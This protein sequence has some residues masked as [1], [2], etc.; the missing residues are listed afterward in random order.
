MKPLESGQIRVFSTCPPSKDSDNRDYVRRVGDIARWSEGAGCEGILVYTDNSLVDPWLL[1]RL[2]VEHTETL[3]PLVAVQPVYMHPYSVAKMVASFGFLHGRRLWLNI[4]AGGF[5]NDLAAMNDDTPHDDRYQRAVEYALII[6]RLLSGTGPVTLAGKYHSVT[7]LKMTPPLDPELEPG[8]MISGSSE[9]GLQAAREIGAMAVRYPKPPGEEEPLTD[10]S[11][12]FGAR[13]GIIA[14]DD[15][16][17]AWKVALER[18][19]EDRRGQITHKLAMKVS[20]SS[21]HHQLSGAEEGD[22]TEENPYWLG[23]FHNYKTF[24]PY[25]VGTYE[26]VGQE[27]ASYLNLGF[28]SFILDVPHRRKSCTTPASPFR[29]RLPASTLD[30]AASG[31]S[32]PAGGA[33]R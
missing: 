29:R 27:L 32:R 30:L 21:W 19:P 20:D 12:D 3:C 9:A 23:P 22:R 6:K 8:I 18:F 4:V 25:L 16:E 1:S 17:L 31:I 14:R 5:K 13:V 11:I 2:I 7:N 26:R 10:D 28:E 15:A 33:S 24:C